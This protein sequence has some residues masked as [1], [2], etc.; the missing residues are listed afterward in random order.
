MYT[1]EA[2][3]ILLDLGEIDRLEYIRIISSLQK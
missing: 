1:K 2:A 3:E